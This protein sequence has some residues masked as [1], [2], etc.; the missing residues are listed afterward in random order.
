VGTVTLSRILFAA[1]AWSYLAGV[2]TQVFL[3]GAGLFE[4]TDWTAHTQLGWSLASAPLILLA[5]SLVAR[6]GRGTILLTAALVLAAMI[7]PELAAAR[8][9]APV[10]AALHPV[11]ALLVFWLT[12]LVARRSAGPLIEVWRRSEGRTAEGRTA[13]STSATSPPTAPPTSRAD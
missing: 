12:W 8:H 3:A 9:E 6:S 1:A 13:V 5:L 4:L 11:N 2:V 10:I 7:Q